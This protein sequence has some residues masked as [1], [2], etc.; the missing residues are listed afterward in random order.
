[1]ICSTMQ[2]RN[3]DIGMSELKIFKGVGKHLPYFFIASSFSS[4]L[5]S[6]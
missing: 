1:M 2:V 5:S 3:A 6:R 4:G